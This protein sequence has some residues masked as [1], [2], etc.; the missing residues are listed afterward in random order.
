M[1]SSKKNKQDDL[2]R[3][4]IAGASYDTVQRYGAAVKE[5]LVAYSGID[6]DVIGEPV[7][8]QKS[9]KSIQGQGTNIKNAFAIRQQKAGWSAEVKDTANKNAEKIINGDKSRKIR[10]D[11]LPNTS[12]NNPLFD[13]TEIDAEGNILAGT[14]TQ[15][16]FIGCSQG[17]PSSV[18]NAERAL[19][20]L[21]SSKF[22]KYIDNDVKIEVP[23]DEY[24]HM[25]DKATSDIKSLETQLENLKANGRGEAATQ[26]ENKINN[27]KRLK[28][29]LKPSTLTRKESLQAVDSPEIS[30]LKSIGK[31]SHEAGIKTGTSAAIIG[32]SASIVR[33]VVD[34]YNGD[35]DIMKAGVDV[36]STT[37]KSGAV[38]YGTG[39]VGTAIKGT[40][41][42]AASDYT[43]ALAKTNLAGT[44]VAVSVSATKTIG[45]CI[46]GEIDGVECAQELGQ[47]G[48]GMIASSMYAAIGQVVIPIPV[49]GGLIGGMVG[50]ALSSATYKILLTSLEDAK[51]AREERIAIEKA[52]EEHIEMIREYR[53]QMNVIIQEYL[54]DRQEIFNESYR[55]IKDALVIGDV[56]L[57]IDSA[58]KI[59]DSLGGN[60]P[61]E[62]IDEFYTKMSNGEGFTI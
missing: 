14:E 1:K 36:A 56:D 37:A 39:F 59:T 3:A 55:G 12:A 41:Q 29:N 46:K 61:F 51:L 16:K 22:Q 49:V 13:H 57:F 53:M 54:S 24:Q 26:I 19:S 60:K 10:Y 21:Q 20:K 30:T 40:M 6:N 15:M 34:V 35:V 5:H 28:K 11:D 4:G 38:G 17:D 45:R 2:I 47:Q 58:N 8:L 9:L 62:T 7:K 50:Y 32:A 31:I 27:L 25:I 44:M 43:R 42:N 33:N 18:G 52:C 48:T 23:K